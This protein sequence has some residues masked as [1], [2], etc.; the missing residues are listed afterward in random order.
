MVR[1]DVVPSTFSRLRGSR[2]GKS[3]LF[4]LLVSVGCGEDPILTKAREADE[5]SKAQRPGGAPGA[6]PSGAPG[7]GGVQ[8]GAGKPEA[9]KPGIPEEPKPGIPDQPPPEGPRGAPGPGI[10][11]PP[12][13]GSSFSGPR[14]ML[15]GTVEFPGYKGGTVR[16]SAFDGA[17]AE[18]AGNQPKIVGEARLE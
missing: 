11:T 6:S 8:S 3:A 4:L 13:P 5:A 2:L 16:V 12:T 7:A 14:V 18:H 1:T 10:P 15:S 9:P 17:H